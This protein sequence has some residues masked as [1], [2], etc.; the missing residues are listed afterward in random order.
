MSLETNWREEVQSEL[1]ELKRIKVGTDEH[2]AAVDGLTK[3]MDRV[4]DSKKIE[5]ERDKFDIEMR[6]LEIEQA[7]I[8]EDRKDRFTRNIITGISVVGGLAGAVWGTIVSLNFEKEGT[9]T[10]QAGRKHIGKV[11]SWFK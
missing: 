5:I 9:F 3:L 6:K 8:D 7:K 1:E 10:S 4:N 11:L 2:R